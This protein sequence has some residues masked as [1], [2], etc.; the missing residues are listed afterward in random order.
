MMFMV[1]FNLEFFEFELFC[2]LSVVRVVR[3]ELFGDFV[4]FL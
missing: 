1:F 3:E 4:G 2:F